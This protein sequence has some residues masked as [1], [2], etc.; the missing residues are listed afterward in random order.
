M[1]QAGNTILLTNLEHHEKNKNQPL[2]APG[3]VSGKHT[4]LPAVPPTKHSCKKFESDQASRP[5]LP[6][7]GNTE[8]C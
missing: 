5:K 1:D 2:Y 8:S 6:I 3:V 7:E 4:I